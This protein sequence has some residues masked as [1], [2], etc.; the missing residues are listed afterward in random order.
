MSKLITRASSINRALDQIGDKWCLLIIEEVFWGINSFTDLMA[1]TG[2]S[3]GVLTDR[4][5]WLISMDCLRQLPEHKGGKRMGYHLTEKSEDIYHCALMAL[6][7]ERQ[8]FSTPALDGVALTHSKCGNTFTPEMRCRCC[9]DE[10]AVWD[11]S[12]KPGPGA[13]WDER[14][15]KVRRRSSISVNKVP[16]KH[17]LY[18]NLINVV[19]DRWTANVIALAFHG[20]SRFDEFHQELPV[21]TNILADRLK[22]LVE[23]SIFEQ[24]VYQLRPKRF[25]YR[26]TTEGERLFPWFLSLLQWGDKWCDPGNRSK[27]MQPT[28]TSCNKKLHGEVVCSHCGGVLKARDVNFNLGDTTAIAG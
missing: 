4:L 19:G 8:F 12:Y 14:D 24:V 2:V 11:V 17:N 6:S 13:T 1:A 21:A 9:K 22:F 20:L 18:R 16:S 27:P 28:H 5:A 10:V 25:E 23:H 7:W 3:R 26:L 15:K